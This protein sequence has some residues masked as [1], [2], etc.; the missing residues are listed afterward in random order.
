M[1][2]NNYNIQRLSTSSQA[3]DARGIGNIGPI[4]AKCP[5][6]N[7]GPNSWPHQEFSVKDKNFLA[8]GWDRVAYQKL[9]SGRWLQALV[10][11]DNKFV[12]I[13]SNVF[14]GNPVKLEVD[15]WDKDTRAYRKVRTK[16]TRACFTICLYPHTPHSSGGST[17]WC[18]SLSRLH[19]VR[20]SR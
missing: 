14:I 11:R 13:L 8:R 10:W 15:R 4:N 9:P 12:K 1:L 16:F 20:R 19:A 2:Y 7:A 3:L 18:K 17:P 6:K 5:A